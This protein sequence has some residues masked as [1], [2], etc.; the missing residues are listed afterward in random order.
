[1]WWF[2]GINGTL[3]FFW[4][5]LAVV[6]KMQIATI[7]VWL[8]ACL[9]TIFMS[10]TFG[11]ILAM[12]L[13]ILAEADKK[14][15]VHLDVK[16]FIRAISTLEKSIGKPMMQWVNEDL[17]KEA[18]ASLK[19]AAMYVK[20]I[21]NTEKKA[22]ELAPWRKLKK[23]EMAKPAKEGFDDLFEL[24]TTLFPIP[25]SRGTYFNEEVKTT[26][27]APVEKS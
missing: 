4:I 5:T 9:G 13:D 17:E 26:D 27:I 24:L 14:D 25:K 6:Y 8:T 1:L 19:R 23:Y 11:P 3:F 18:V 12:L 20:T 15:K 21:E 16:R 10:F 2:I 7:P 22:L